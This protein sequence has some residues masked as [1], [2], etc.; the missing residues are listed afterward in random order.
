MGKIYKIRIDK[1]KRTGQKPVGLI[2]N[3]NFLTFSKN[4]AKTSQLRKYP[5]DWVIDH[6]EGDVK[7]FDNGFNFTECGVYKVFEK[8]GAEKYVPFICL[9]DF[10]QGNIY[11]FV[12]IRTQTIGNGDPIYF[13]ILR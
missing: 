9:V 1:L 5:D 2:F 3:D 10:A 11:G 7:S 12:F 8:L 4:L 6:V 13:K